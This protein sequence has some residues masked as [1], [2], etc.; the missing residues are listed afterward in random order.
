M[1]KTVPIP[2]TAANTTAG[3]MYVFDISFVDQSTQTYYLADRSNA[4]VDVVDAR[5]NELITQLSATPAFKGFTGN[6]GTSGPN[7]VVAAFPWL[8]VTDANSR[9]VTIDLRN[10]KTVADVSTGGTP[11]LRADEMAYDPRDGLLMAVNNAD[12]PPFATLINVNKAT[13]A[14]MVAKR[15]SFDTMDTGVNATNGAEQPVWDPVSGKFY[16]SIPQIGPNAKDGAV[17]R[18]STAGTVEAQYPIE[19]CSPAGLTL[20]PNVDLLVGCNTV[21]DTAGNLWDSTKDVT[22][23]PIQVIIDAWTGK[24][25]ATV[26]GV[27][28]GDEVWFNSGDGN[29]YTASST[30]PLRPTEVVAGTPL[31]AQGAAIL[32]VIDARDQALKQLVPTFN[33]PATTGPTAHAASTA[34]SVAANA[35]N[36]HVFVPLGANNVFPD[37]VTGCIAVYGTGD[38]EE[39]AAR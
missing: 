36:N 11:G 4:V 21:F 32:G 8:F 16:V 23:A 33:V 3:K 2:G 15:I 18:I 5:T 39:T 28:V 38:R 12:T 19:F 6:N 14:L 13:G 24:I 37:C 25:D 1:L 29:Y 26:P 10:G 27:G 9:V 22:A 20:G 35:G 30:S 17:V 31:T 34:H 7:G